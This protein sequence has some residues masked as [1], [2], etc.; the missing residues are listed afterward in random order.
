MKK[1]ILD[2]NVLFS[3]NLRKLFL[4][5]SWN[6]LCEIVWSNE[7]WDEIFR[8]YSTDPAKK[9][10]FRKHV[11][12]VIFIKFPGL[13]RVLDGSQK[14]IGLPDKDDEHV[15]ALAR[16]EGVS[17]IVTFNLKDFPKDLLKVEGLTRVHPDSF[18]CEMFEEMPKKMKVTLSQAIGSYTDSKPS[19]AKYF[20]SLRKTGV[21]KFVDMLEMADKTKNLFPEVWS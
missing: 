13:M 9:E 5:L 15:V 3:N 16:Q 18:L 8:N 2:A 21:T 12:D 7:I 4:W 11:A 10:E 14:P 17:I 20:E 1:I 19:K 6:N